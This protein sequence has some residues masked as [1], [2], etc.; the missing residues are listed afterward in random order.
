MPSGPEAQHTFSLQKN[1]C[2]PNNFL[3]I[4][5]QQI[6]IVVVTIS[7]VTTIRIVTTT[8]TV[9]TV[10]NEIVL[11]TILVSEAIFRRVL[12]VQQSHFLRDTASGCY[13]SLI[14]IEK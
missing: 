4:K 12:L 7:I 8:N 9:I 3:L 10:S 11:T 1:D 6:R 5:P 14:L 2:S 13:V